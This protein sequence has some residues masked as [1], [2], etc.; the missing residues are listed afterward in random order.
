[1]HDDDIETGIPNGFEA[2]GRPNAMR[3]DGERRHDELLA[4]KR[5]G[6]PAMVRRFDT[7]EEC[8]RTANRYRETLHRFQNKPYF[9]RERE[10]C[11]LDGISVHVRGNEMYVVKDER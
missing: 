6:V 7:K 10:R 3:T 9:K 1:M 4:F 2:C 8:K 5:S 11:D